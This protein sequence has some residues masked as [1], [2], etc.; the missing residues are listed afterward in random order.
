MWALE[1]PWAPRRRPIL[2]NTPVALIVTLGVAWLAVAGL[3]AIGWLPASVLRVVSITA[4]HGGLL[5]VA[6]AWGAADSGA[7]LPPGTALITVGLVGAGAAATVIDSRACVVYL[8][9]PTW[10]AVLALR[11]RLVGLSLGPGAPWRAVVIGGAVGVLL[12]GHLLLSASQ[13]L[14]HPLRGG[15]WWPLLALWAYDVGA[16]IISAECF[17]RGALFN[18]L[19]RRWSFV[20]AAALATSVA[21]LRYLVDPLLP[22]Q[23]EVMAG[24]LFYLTTLGVINCW[25]LWFSGSLVPGLI[26]SL[27]FFVA[28]RM[29]ATG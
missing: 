2:A 12:G 3:A 10:L 26:S 7:C 1:Q 18:R 28:Y 15:G 5:V 27:L 19:Q 24:A 4:A 11:G 16:N 20:A 13:T 29:L 14:G 21:L 23:I 6:L 22:R 8:A 17:F 9:A 25:L